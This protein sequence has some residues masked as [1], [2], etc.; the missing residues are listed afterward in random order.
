MEW[1]QRVSEILVVSGG[2]TRF[3]LITL[4]S[5]YTDLVSSPRR[6]RNVTVTLEEEVAQWARIEAARRD[7]SVSRWLGELLRE[8]MSAEDDYE[9]AMRRAV[10][11]KPF[12]RSDGR[13]L[14]REEVH[15][16]AGT[17]SLIDFDEAT[18]GPWEWDL[19]RLVASVN[20][21]GRE[22]GLN[23]HERARRFN[24]GCRPLNASPSLGD[25]TV[26]LHAVDGRIRSST[27]P[28][29][30]LRETLAKR[31]TGNRTFLAK[32]PPGSGSGFRVLC[33]ADRSTFQRRYLRLT[34]PASRSG[35]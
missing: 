28:N 18:I 31:C 29:Q 10:G 19:K 2:L 26:V 8:R 30:R 7:T 24:G 15:D 14:T 27:D 34:V 5:C 3:R 16:R 21:A 12:L 9:K 1:F 25:S 13:Y 4:I 35:A 22:N 23:R 32:T 33:R 20:V 17:V 6:L 11:R